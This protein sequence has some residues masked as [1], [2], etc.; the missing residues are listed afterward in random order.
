MADD[1]APEAS[2]AVVVAAPAVVEERETAG[3]CV[4]GVIETVVAIDAPPA[5]SGFQATRFAPPASASATPSFRR[6]RVLVLPKPSAS[7]VRSVVFSPALAAAPSDGRRGEGE[8]DESKEVD[9]EQDEEE[10]EEQDREVRSIVA[11][12]APPATAVQV[13]DTGST[14]ATSE[15]L[16]GSQPIFGFPENTPPTDFAASGG[17][18]LVVVVASSLQ[19]GNVRPAATPSEEG[20]ALVAAV[21]SEVLD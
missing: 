15:H 17:W 6:L 1:V 12:D 8:E 3:C 20:R 16:D 7:N 19:V 10:E 5:H 4:S 9:D 13:A 2:C 14:A 21:G 11:N 18:R